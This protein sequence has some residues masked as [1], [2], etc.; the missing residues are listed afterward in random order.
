MRI[1]R[2]TPTRAFSVFPV[3]TRT[4]ADQRK[5]GPR[6]ARP[7]SG[8][9]SRRRRAG[10]GGAAERVGAL[11]SVAVEE[12]D[13]AAATAVGKRLRV[14]GGIDADVDGDEDEADWSGAHVLHLAL[15]TVEWPRGRP[16]LTRA[17]IGY[18]GTGIRT[19]RI[20]EQ[21]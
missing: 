11:S 7:H 14:A 10:A 6:P 5:E 18:R 21:H 17:P 20:V 1:H 3:T 9:Q 2:T 13:F 12:L 16:V 4:L 8:A 15:P 19:I